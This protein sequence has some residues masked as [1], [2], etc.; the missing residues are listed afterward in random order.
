MT[1]S[2][3]WEQLREKF[4]DAVAAGF[5]KWIADDQPHFGE[6]LAFAVGRVDEGRALLEYLRE[7]VI[8]G[9]RAVVLDVGCGNG[10]VAFAFANDPNAT[11]FGVDTV[12]NPQ[13]LECR[14]VL[15]SPASFVAADGARLPFRGDSIDVALLVDVLEHL[16]RPREVAREILR[17]LRPGG[18][19]VVLTPARLAYA[20]RRDPHF[21]IRGLL[22][23]PNAVQR[24]IV[25]R[26]LKRTPAYDVTH[27]YW[28][29]RE[30]VRLFAEASAVDVLYGH[31]VMPPPPVLR[32]WLRY[33]RALA[34]WARYRARRFFFGW[35]FVYKGEP[36][37]AA[38]T[39]DRTFT[40]S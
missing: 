38:G 22:L 35:M 39:F 4:A 20:F 40:R 8:G 36:P 19:C 32:Y 10:G 28:H 9:R 6:Q 3:P 17:V 37:V 15:A 24:F 21:G 5:R 7:R 1:R 30:I 12:P 27:T 2:Q 11:V 25:D 33:P 13:A 14:R 18:V 16:E 29:A 23:L 34:Q 26:I 31:N